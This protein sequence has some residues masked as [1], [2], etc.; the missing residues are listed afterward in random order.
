MPDLIKGIP[1]LIYFDDIV[2]IDPV[3]DPVCP[4]ADLF[5]SFNGNDPVS[6]FH[7]HHL[8]KPGHF[9]DLIDL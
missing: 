4:A 5:G 1:V 8:G 7:G 2:L 6:L 3:N 9:K